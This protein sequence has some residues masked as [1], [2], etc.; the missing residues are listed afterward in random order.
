M[1]ALFIWWFSPKKRFSSV[2]KILFGGFIAFVFV[3]SV[4]NNSV[5]LIDAFRNPPL[6]IGVSHL[7]L[8]V[9]SSFMISSC[10]WAGLFYLPYCILGSKKRYMIRIL[11]AVLTIGTMF[12]VTA[13]KEYIAPYYPTIEAKELTAA[14]AKLGDMNKMGEFYTLREFGYDIARI[15]E[16]FPD[17]MIT[18]DSGF[19]KL[20]IFYKECED[21]WADY[22]ILPTISSQFRN[23][24][25]ESHIEEEAMLLF[26]GMVDKSIFRLGTPEWE[27]VSNL[28]VTWFGYF[29]IDKRM[30]PAFANW[31]LLPK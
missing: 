2:I 23:E 15:T 22:Y 19:P 3:S 9:I 24:W 16:P 12:S 5:D 13:A 17:Y 30:H 29:E 31:T 18:E 25:R 1:K 7:V 14:Q 21:K 10:L 6:F 27:K 4:I 26:W 28:L 11:L 20:V 8:P